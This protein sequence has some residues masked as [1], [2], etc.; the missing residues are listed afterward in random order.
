VA[1]AKGGTGKTTVA[2]NLAA[3]YQDQD[4]ALFIDADVEEPNAALFLQPEWEETR[5]VFRKLPIV[6]EGLCDGCGKC[7]DFCAFGAI[8]LLGKTPVILP[9]TCHS[10][11]GC[12]LVCPKNAI[13]EQ[14][15][16]LGTFQSG[17]SG[18]LRLISAELV[19]GNASGVPLVRLEKETPFKGDLRIVDCPPGTGCTV[20]EAVR[21]CDFCVLVTEPTPFGLHD[22]KAA[23]ALLRSLGLPFGVVINRDGMGDKETE[24]YCR[25]E[26]VPL[27]GKIPYDRRIALSYAGGGVL[28][29][30]LP[31]YTAIFEKLWERITELSL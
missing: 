23:A 24:E 1:G 7:A 31:E 17:R 9:E 4:K 3:V 10:C 29:K 21:D 6:D 16:V 14:D 2:L 22:L 20:T 5:E 11:G 8:L 26:T 28:V 12:A 25:R 13:R 18:A 19:V 30:D 15:F 27:L